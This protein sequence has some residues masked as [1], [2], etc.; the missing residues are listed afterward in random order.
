MLVLSRYTV[1]DHVKSLF[2]KASVSS[3]QGLVAR[4]FLDNYLPH[5][6]G[7]TPLTAEG[8]FVA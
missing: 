8:A 3:W 7:R 2:E 6:A 1:Q 5:L 4:V